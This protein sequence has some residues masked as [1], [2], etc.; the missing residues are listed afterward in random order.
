VSLLTLLFVLLFGLFGVGSG[1]SS[2]SG[3]GSSSSS[4]SGTAQPQR[5]IKL[6]DSGRTVTLRRGE[7][8]VL[9]LPSRWAWGVPATTGRAVEL[10]DISSFRDTGFTEWG[11]DAARR[12]TWTFRTAGQPGSKR[13]SVK[14]HVR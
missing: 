2:S 6:A 1:S 9:R 4:G 5:V 14:I 12:G 13:F 8:A 10:S 3:S 7:Q 11:L